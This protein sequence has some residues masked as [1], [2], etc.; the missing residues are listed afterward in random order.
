MYAI[1]ETGGK[2]Y[3]AEQ[4]RWLEVELL[5][6]PEGNTVNFP[7]LMVV[8]GDKTVVGAPH[9]ETA[10]VTGKVLKEEVKGKKSG[11]LQVPRQKKAISA[12]WVI[13]KNTPA[14]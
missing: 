14:C 8:D 10:T 13:V 2:Q 9:V 1:I 5:Y 12:K 7:A 11:F 6:A 4:G 3:K